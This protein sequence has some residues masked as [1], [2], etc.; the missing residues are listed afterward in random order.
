M[1]A[2]SHKDIGEA[3]IRAALKTMGVTKDNF[4]KKYHGEILEIKHNGFTVFINAKV[5]D[6]AMKK[7]AQNGKG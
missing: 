7:Q 1:A 4:P 3:L 5:F 2:W 6:E